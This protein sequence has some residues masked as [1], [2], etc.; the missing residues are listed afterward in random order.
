M[1]QPAHH[2]EDR[3]DVQHNL[4]G[5]VRF[6]GGYWRRF[7]QPAAAGA[8]AAKDPTKEIA[9]SRNPGAGAWA[10]LGAF[11]GMAVMARTEPR[12]MQT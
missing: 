4:R 5:L 12:G 9:G 2:R 8:G 6:E 3:L 1:Y 7:A 11:R 10:K